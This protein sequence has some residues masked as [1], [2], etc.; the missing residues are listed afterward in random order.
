MPSLDYKQFTISRIEAFL[1]QIQ[2]LKELDFPYLDSS[3]ALDKISKHITDQHDAVSKSVLIDDALKSRC[4]RASD[5]LFIFQRYLGYIS[6]SSEPINSFEIYFSFRRL[7]ARILGEHTRLIISSEWEYYSPVNFSIP[8]ELSNFVFIG[9]PVAEAE[10]PLIVPLS[11]HELGHSI[12]DNTSFDNKYR[13]L[14]QT[15]IL[16]KYSSSYDNTEIGY[17]TEVSL[18]KCIEYF[19]DFIGIGLFGESY[20]YSFSYLLAPKISKSLNQSHP[21]AKNRAIAM[22]KAAKHFN[23]DLPTNF[24]NL[25]KTQ[26]NPSINRRDKL[27]EISENIASSQVDA[28][29]Q[30]VSILL[31]NKGVIYAKPS[32]YSELKSQILSGVPVSSA[33]SLADITNVAW[34]VYFEENKWDD[35]KISENKKIAFLNEL[36]IKSYEILEINQRL[37]E[38]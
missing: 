23:N 9:L 8:T 13:A 36:T 12:W 30:D 28:L 17:M 38:K 18:I 6:K 33:N 32:N 11:G 10:N 27:L 34:D 35:I 16:T 24:E 22:L 15:E 20:L 31:K 26:L 3:E 4:S 7:A 37:L 2:H 29:I 1:K 21:N 5:Q 19:C 25:F 14:L